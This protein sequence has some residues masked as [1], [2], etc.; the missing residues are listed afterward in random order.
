MD[1]QD[2]MK[3]E[4]RALKFL[5]RIRVDLCLVNTL[6]SIADYQNKLIIDNWSVELQ[7]SRQG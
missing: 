3:I 2:Y 1:L 6:S 4:I 5:S 7:K